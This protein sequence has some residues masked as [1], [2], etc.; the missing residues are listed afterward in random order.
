MGISDYATLAGVAAI[1]W[2]LGNL[3]RDMSD[4]RERL[5][6]LEGGFDVLTKALIDRREDPG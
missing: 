4:V 1:L 3:H 6:R 5:A 2:F